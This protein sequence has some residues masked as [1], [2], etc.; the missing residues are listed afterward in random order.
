MFTPERKSGLSD[1]LHVKNS[2]KFIPMRA[3]ERKNS[4]KSTVLK[5]TVGSS[6][7]NESLIPAAKAKKFMRTTRM[8]SNTDRNK[9]DSMLH[10]DSL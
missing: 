1:R 7:I 4:N 10:M 8:Y 9:G 2:N 5:T 3:T 6:E